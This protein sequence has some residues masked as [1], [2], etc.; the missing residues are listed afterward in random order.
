MPENKPNKKI[1]EDHKDRLFRLVFGREEYKAATLSLYN[2]ITGSDYTD[3]EEL[4]INTIEDAVY[5][6]MHNDVSFIIA[7]TLNLYEHQSSFSPN[8]PMRMLLYVSQLY[9]KMLEVNP[10][11]SNRMHTH[12]KVMFPAPKFYVFFNGV[13]KEPEER[14][15]EITDCFMDQSNSDLKLSVKMFNINYGSNKNLMEKCSPLS[16]YS[17]F[18]HDVRKYKI[19]GKDAKEAVAQAIELLPHGLV[20]S[21]LIA[22]KAE[23]TEMYLTE[24]DHEQTLQGTYEVGVEDGMAKGMAEANRKTARAM[25]AEG[26]NEDLVSKCTSLPVEEVRKLKL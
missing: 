26:L 19:E 17:K 21:I 7:E 10:N 5:L 15:L 4:E 25:L 24:Y 2:A 9:S 3:P 1:K 14:V 22:H 11:M 13:E 6:N 12:S 8:I 20:K 18:I 23:A 16:D